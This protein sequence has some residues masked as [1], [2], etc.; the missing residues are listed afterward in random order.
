VAQ[1]VGRSANEAAASRRVLRGL[2]TPEGQWPVRARPQRSA[3]GGVHPSPTLLG[4]GS[5]PLVF[6]SG[7]RRAGQALPLSPPGW[8]VSPGEDVPDSR[9]SRRVEAPKPAEWVALGLVPPLGD[10]R[11]SGHK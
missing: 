2:T 1:G 7:R 9:L 11:A 10:A 5:P 4:D 6:G 8:T 3:P